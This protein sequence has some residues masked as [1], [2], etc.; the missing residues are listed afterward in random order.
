MNKTEFLIGRSGLDLAAIDGNTGLSIG[1]AIGSNI[2]NIALVLGVSAIITPIEVKS[3]VLK[4]EWLFLMVVTLITGYLLWDR[5]LG[6]VDGLILASLLILFLTYT[7][8]S[9]KNSNNHEFDE[10][11]QTVNKSQTTKTWLMLVMGLIVLTSSAKLI[12]ALPMLSP[13]LPSIAAKPDTNISGAEVPKP[14]CS[15]GR[16]KVNTSSCRSRSTTVIFA[17]P[18]CSLPWQRNVSLCYYV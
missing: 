16:S 2:F 18:S 12:V 6:V 17:R 15:A 7:L 5:Y 3:E 9:A 11:E 8:I 14:K 10:F 1:N 13:V 4:K